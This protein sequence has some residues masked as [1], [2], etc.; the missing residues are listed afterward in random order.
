RQVV[1][2]VGTIRMIL[3]KMVANHL[4]KPRCQWNCLLILALLLELNQLLLQ[5]PDL[6]RDVPDAA[7]LRFIRFHAD[8]ADGGPFAITVVV[9]DVDFLAVLVRH[10]SWMVIASILPAAKDPTPHFD[11][12]GQQVDARYPGVVP[13]V[14]T[15]VKAIAFHRGDRARVPER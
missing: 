3:T 9:S 1:Q 12:E 14:K 4:T 13:I 11:I 15:D 5:L 8:H 7:P 10:G 2:A 6:Q